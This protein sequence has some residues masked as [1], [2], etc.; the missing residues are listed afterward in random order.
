MYQK[1]ALELSAC[2]APPLPRS[3][4]SMPRPPVPIVFCTLVGRHERLQGRLVAAC[5][6]CGH[7][8]RPCDQRA[9]TPT[10][11][12]VSIN[13][14]SS[15]LPGM[16]ASSLCITSSTRSGA[17]CFLCRNRTSH[18]C[19]AKP[20]RLDFAHFDNLGCH[21]PVVDAESLRVVVISGNGLRR[22][23]NKHVCEDWQTKHPNH[24]RTCSRRP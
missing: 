5:R 15:W 10:R 23:Q 22:S 2:I 4:P 7:H 24:V 18:L 12:E 17:V 1:S 3:P 19:H 8:H 11:L 21:L 9:P 20:R 16:Y 14:F 13:A 6:E